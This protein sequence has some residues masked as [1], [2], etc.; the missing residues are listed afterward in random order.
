LRKT[1]GGAAKATLLPLRQQCEKEG[2]RD[3]IEEFVK[4]EAFLRVKKTSMDTR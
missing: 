2:R 1:G 4:R 3:K